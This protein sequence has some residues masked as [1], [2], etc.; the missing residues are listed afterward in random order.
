MLRSFKTF[1]AVIVVL[2][3]SGLA[4]R[5]AHAA[6]ETLS[7][8][9]QMWTI[10]KTAGAS[11]VVSTPPES[12]GLWVENSTLELIEPLDPG[13]RSDVFVLAATFSEDG[14]GCV[15]LEIGFPSLGGGDWVDSVQ[16]D[17]LAAAGRWK[18]LAQVARGQGLAKAVRY[19]ITVRGGV[20]LREAELLAGSAGANIRALRA[21]VASPTVDALDAAIREVKAR[22]TYRSR[23][24]WPLATAQALAAIVDGETRRDALPGVQLI[25][26]ALG[27]RHSWATV[28][29]AEGRLTANGKLV[30]YRAP[31]S[32]L[33]ALDEQHLAGWLSI[34]LMAATGGPEAQQYAKSIR[35]GLAE[36][37]EAGACGFVVDLTAHSGGN[38]WPGLEGLGPLLGADAA[39][40]AFKPGPVWRIDKRA[41]DD[42][43]QV[44]RDEVAQMPVAVLLGP[45]TASSGEALAVAFS[46]RPHTE[47]FGAKTRGLATSTQ[48]VPLG[49]GLVA[50]VVV[51]EM[52]DR[53]GRTFPHGIVPLTED[54]TSEG[55]ATRALQWLRGSLSCGARSTSS[56]APATAE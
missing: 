7:I 51:A 15:R 45:E 34:P 25:L 24:D 23:V 5:P 11:E 40:G 10:L 28:L 30:P 42:D 35:A 1:G 26:K 6:V 18:Q 31:Q 9:G 44:W 27:D 16:T 17:C 21:R 32:R 39:V 14:G 41:Q 37:L 53:L 47:F 29:D 50:F 4:P 54:A 13:I 48:M 52:A 20:R 3:L 49:D 46:G 2:S 33:Q 22:A 12:P 55:A 8:G 19:R 56:L 38:M 43:A 36:A